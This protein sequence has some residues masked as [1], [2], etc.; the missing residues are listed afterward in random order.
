MNDFTSLEPLTDKEIREA[1]EKSVSLIGMRREI[2]LSYLPADLKVRLI[3]SNHKWAVITYDVWTEP[4]CEVLDYEQAQQKLVYH[5]KC[6]ATAVPPL[7]PCPTVIVD[8]E[9]GVVQG[10]YITSEADANVI[11]IDRD[12]E[13]VN[14]ESVE[15]D[16]FYKSV[17]FDK[18]GSYTNYIV[19]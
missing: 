2:Q 18:R 5:L 8:T 1:Y 4:K 13:N 9:G 14:G 12:E 3:P 6:G 10:I 7:I 19:K 16:G 15:I 17:S 11:V